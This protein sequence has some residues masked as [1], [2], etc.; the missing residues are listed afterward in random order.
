LHGNRKAYRL[1]ARSGGSAAG[2]YQAEQAGLKLVL[3]YSSSAKT[4]KVLV[5]PFVTTAS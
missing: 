4:G 2:G 5:I 1:S 3:R